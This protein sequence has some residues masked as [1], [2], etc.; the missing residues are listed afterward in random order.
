ML[1]SYGGEQKPACDWRLCVE[2]ETVTHIKA[3]WVIW[4]EW[5][6]AQFCLQTYDGEAVPADTSCC[7]FQV[8]FHSHH[9]LYTSPSSQCVCECVRL[10]SR[11]L[12][13]RALLCLTLSSRVSSSLTSVWTSS[14]A[15]LK[16]THKNTVTHMGT[17]WTF[18]RG[19][20]KTKT[21]FRNLIFKHI[22]ASFRLNMT[23]IFTDLKRHLMKIG[24][25]SW[26]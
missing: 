19:C 18:K 15:A 5:N 26:H 3:K 4:P 25:L 10:W 13:G 20:I 24:Q 16:E 14:M 8:N 7:F 11:A 21:I 9:L 1:I 2:P 22:F 12:R 17:L 23:P 6:K